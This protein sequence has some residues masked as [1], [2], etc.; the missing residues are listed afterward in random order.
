[1]RPRS[2]IVLGAVAAALYGAPAGAAPTG[3]APEAVAG[4]GAVPAALAGAAPG[5]AATAA[6]GAAAMPPPTCAD[7]GTG[8]DFPLET[9]IK[10]GP[11]EYRAGDARRAWTVEL[12]NTTNLTC[13]RIHPVLVLVDRYRT[14]LPRQVRLEFH[15][16]KRWRPV[17][18]ER[19]DRYENIGVLAGEGFRGFT[20]GPDSTVK[21]SV[22]FALT[23]DT[24]ANKVIANAAIVQRRGDDGAWVGESGDYRFEVLSAPRRERTPRA[25]PPADPDAP[26]T[27]ETPGRPQSS[28][29]SDTPEDPADTADPGHPSYPADPGR[30]TAPSYPA[31]PDPSTDPPSSRA[32]EPSADRPFPRP[33]E[34]GTD[35]PS[36]TRPES[37]AP[38]TDPA[39]PDRHD[40]H[41][42][43][44][45]PGTPDRGELAETGTAREHAL[46]LGLTAA[47]LVAAGGLLATL[48]RR[49][50]TER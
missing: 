39:D 23:E 27:R 18:L 34:P 8:R 28:T 43:P 20:V 17:G 3:V 12:A 5:A 42:R 49:L 47:A 40:R 30:P 10:G 37:P 45:D 32:S 2:V 9:R 14:L 44:H 36:S 15:D 21:V 11:A 33:S 13:S 4:G 46:G 19:T 35:R 48:S 22:R 7:P 25:E 41:D 50:R 38:P 6:P 26:G 1:M 24:E 29:G 16:G 31:V